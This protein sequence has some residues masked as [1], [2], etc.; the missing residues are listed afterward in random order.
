MF[1]FPPERKE[2]R[3]KKKDIRSEFFS[4]PYSHP[5]YIYRFPLRATNSSF[6]RSI[7]KKNERNSTK[8]R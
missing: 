6:D 3:R 2:R 7:A 5:I 8:T 4:S 1:W